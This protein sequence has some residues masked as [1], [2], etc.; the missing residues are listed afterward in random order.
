MEKLKLKK[1]KGPHKLRVETECIGRLEIKR[2]IKEFHELANDPNM[3][4]RIEF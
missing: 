2:I 4:L 3:N 1:L